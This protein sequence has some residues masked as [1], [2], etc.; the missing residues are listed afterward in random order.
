MPEL[1]SSEDDSED[2]PERN[3]ILDSAARRA[4]QARNPELMKSVE[5]LQM[6]SRV[7]NEENPVDFLLFP[8]ALAKVCPDRKPI[9]LKRPYYWTRVVLSVDYENPTP[10][11]DAQEIFRITAPRL[12]EVSIRHYMPRKTITIRTWR[13]KR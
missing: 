2:E 8:Y 11:E 4:R 13:K 6:V 5:I 7:W 9:L 12:L 1:A 3:H 10:L